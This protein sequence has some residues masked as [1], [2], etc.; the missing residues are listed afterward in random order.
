MSWSI[1]ASGEVDDVVES[2][3]EQF[4]AP[5]A[6]P[7]AGLTDEG[8]R[9]TVKMVSDLVDQC[10][11]TFAADRLVKVS[12]NGH[13]GYNDWEKKAGAY[14]EVRVEIGILHG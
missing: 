6:E 12:A 14:Q 4:A 10:L 13:L 3:A 1:N 8:E 7:P 2:I 9:E 5:L 11:G